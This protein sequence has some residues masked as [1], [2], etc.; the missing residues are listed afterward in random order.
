[1]VASRSSER[2]R[3]ALQQDKVCKQADGRCHSSWETN[4]ELHLAC[5]SFSKI[6][7]ARDVSDAFDPDCVKT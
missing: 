5:R 2:N 4:I 6:E 3:E 1:M 7:L